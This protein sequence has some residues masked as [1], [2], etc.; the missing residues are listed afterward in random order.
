MYIELHSHSGYSFLDGTTPPEQLV[1]AA[2]SLGY[3]ALALTDHHGLYGSMA[4]AQ[5]ARQHGI[6]AITGAELTLLDGAH[7]TLLAETATGYANLCRLI[8]EAHLGREDRRDPR[9][10][11]A[12]LEARH[13]GLI[14]LSGCRDGLLPRVLRTEGRAAARKLAERCR[15]V[16]GRDGFFVELQRNQVYGD[17]ALTQSLADL[18]DLADLAVVATG[19]VHYDRRERHRLHDVLTAIR[20]R[21]TLDGSHAVRRPN[22][23]FYLRPPEEVA[24]L[25]AD[26]EDAIVHTEA[27]AQRCAAFDLTRDLGYR[28]PDFAGSDHAPAPRALAELCRARLDERYPEGSEHR[29][30]ARR[31]L[32][33][34]LRLIELHQLSG[35]FLVYNDLFDLAREVA[36]DV[37]AGSRRVRGNLLPGRGRG[38]SVSSVVCYLL[39]LSHVDPVATRLFIGRFLN[40][41]LASVPDID[42]DFP[43]EIREELIRRVYTR[44]GAEHAGLV[45]SFPTYRLRSAVREIGKALDLPPGEIEL[46]ARLADRRAGGLREELEQLPGFAGRS[47]APLWKELCELAEEIAG[48]PRHLSQHVGGMVISSRPLVEIVPLERAAMEDRVVCQW[49]KDSCDDARFIKVDFLALGMLSLVEECVELVARRT[50]TPP[51]LS[52]IDFEDTAVYD[53]ICDGDTVG[54]FQIESRAQIQM[55]RRTRPR[56]LEDLAVEVAIV[57]PGPIVGGAVNPY[58]RRREEQRRARLEG[59]PYDVP[60][61]H[62][63]LKDALEETLGVILYQDQ[64]LQVCQALAGFTA[65]QAEALRRAM[66]RRRSRALM[67]GFWEEFKAGAAARGVPETIAE[68]VFSQVIAFSEFGFPK[69]HAAAFGLLAY[70]SAWLRHYHPVEY[71]VGL[72][73]NQPMG[74]YSLDA[75]GRDAKRNGVTVLLPDVNR[76]DVWCTVD[77][78]LPIADC[79]LETPD[80]ESAIRVGLGFVRDWSEATATAVVQERE[81]RG[82]FR[83]VGDFVRRAPPPLKRPAIEHLV[84]VGGCDDFGLTRRELLWQVGLWLPPK[85]DRSDDARGRRQLELPLDHPYERLRFG[86]LGSEE[87]LLAEYA[88]LGFAASGHPLSLVRESLPEDMVR[89]D[90]LPDVPAGTGVAVAGL[91]VARQRPQTAKGFIFLLLEDETGMINVIVRPDVYERFR[92]AVRGEPFVRVNGKLTR[93]G[94]RGGRGGSMNVIAEEVSGLAAGRF[95]TA[96]RQVAPESKDWG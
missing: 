6:Q 77:C 89:S 54:L 44:Y 73:N 39:G 51:D 1:L 85:A 56:N 50:G 68:K 12:S 11:F 9:L 31:R 64:V 37:R 84:W 74:F 87:R 24:R 92:T 16:F 58:V 72:F 35:F 25:F 5:A 52:R 53:R 17:R 96:M 34:E 36:A 42:L 33:E 20:H 32:A 38:S 71:Y 45:C 46:V 66:S 81:A 67:G 21:S 61:D 59:R 14:V 57:R 60:L 3:P 63:L 19:D 49:D 7:V 29:D 10:D 90:R 78:G 18:A 15:A 43:R 27:I 91:V 55:I 22:S 80:V 23:E 8:T 28:F 93:D 26:R 79:G 83:S 62:P 94:D 88:T 82:P 75:L 69:S 86:G 47:Q 4:F 2:A 13:E 40:E 41:T 95:I 76:S 70:Q 65:G 48:L 30:E